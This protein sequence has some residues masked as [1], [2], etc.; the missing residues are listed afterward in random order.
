MTDAVALAVLAA[1]ML[2]VLAVLAA[3][4][5]WYALALSR[6]FSTRETD[7]WRAWVPV[8]NEAEL[9]RLGGQDPVKA[10]LFLVPLVNLYAVVLKAIAA[11]RIGRDA[12]RAGG[13]VA[14]AVLIPPLWATLLG[15]PGRT[16]Q[17]AGATA[18][19]TDVASG[20]GAA[21]GAW[22]AAAPAGPSTVQPVAPFA[23]P[24]APSFPASAPAPVPAAFPAPPAATPAP[25]SAVP[26]PAPAAFTT[27]AAQASAPAAPTSAPAPTAP[28]SYA[29]PRATPGASPATSDV[30]LTRRQAAGLRRDGADESTALVRAP[31]GWQL[32]LPTGETVSLSERV[33]VLGR[34]PRPE[35]G[36]QIVAIEDATKT[37]SKRHARLEW[38]GQVWTITDLGSTNGVTLRDGAAER[39]ITAEQPTSATE[40]FLLGDAALS[41]RRI[42]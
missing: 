25:A 8:M 5:V 6:V 41:L 34:N 2:V 32:V 23:A 17:A 16:V 42:P 38:T 4:H 37:M 13:L 40:V 39:L 7:P 22:T 26:T 18:A 15:S 9:L 14:L 20:G 3:W 1:G 31:A 35:P 10:A 29:A 19:T 30:P 28:S 21:S 33:V 24:P 27:P 12:E 36:A 11:H